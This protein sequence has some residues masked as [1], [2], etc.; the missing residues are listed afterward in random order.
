MQQNLL[1]QVLNLACLQ[2]YSLPHMVLFTAIACLAQ[3]P[4]QQQTNHMAA[5][6]SAW[7]QNAPILDGRRLIDSVAYVCIQPQPFIQHFVEP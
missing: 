5:F 2:P 3:P 1:F 4:S 7:A 6:L